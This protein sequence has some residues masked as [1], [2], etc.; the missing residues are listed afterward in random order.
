[1]RGESRAVET[2]QPL[3]RAGL[4]ECRSGEGL[5]T[6][7]SG[8]GFWN[9]EA[10]AVSLAEPVLTVVL[11]LTE[12]PTI[13][14]LPCP[15]LALPQPQCLGSDFLHLP[16][17][18]PLAQSPLWH[19]HFPSSMQRILFLPP[20]LLPNLSNASR[21]WGQSTMAATEDLGPGGE[22]RSIQPGQEVHVS[23]FPH[24]QGLIMPPLRRC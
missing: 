24:M 2:G 16:P 7:L 6:P 9:P 8:G 1:M 11:V 19:F 12:A 13:S 21:M 17:Q 4:G 20:P 18:L 10:V 23:Q 15:S 14:P 3:Q 22:F 5:C